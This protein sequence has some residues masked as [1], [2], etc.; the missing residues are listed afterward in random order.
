M[1]TGSF[2]SRR[3]LVQG[4]A[5]LTLGSTAPA[6]AAPR[7]LRGETDLRGSLDAAPYGVTPKPGELSG[8]RFAAMLKR[9]AADNTPVFLPPGTYPVE[10]LDL[11][12]NLRLSGVAGASRLLYT[13]AGSMLTARRLRRA[14]L[15]NL[16][17]DGGN[18][19]LGGEAPALLH[20]S[21]VGELIIDNCDIVGASK[22]A[23][24]LERCAARIAGNRISG[25]ADY[26]LYAVD[27]R[28]TTISGNRVSACGNGGILVHR[29]Q[30]GRDGT[31]VTGN[32]ITDIR[33]ANGG[34]GPFGNA[35]NVFRADN[36]M[37]GGN[38]IS[39]AAFSAIRA[40]AASDVQIFDNQCLESGETAIYS[41]FGFEGAMV[42]GNLI[43][44]AA[45]G[46]SVVNFDSGGRL[47]TIA[48]NMVRNIS[49][50][51]PYVHDN[52][53]FGF[54]ISA[55]ADAAITG[56]VVENIARF[57]MLV[58]W[59]PY[60]RNVLASGNIIRRAQTGMAVSVVEDAGQALIANNLFDETPKGAIVGYRWHDAATRDL[61]DGAS[62]F[63]HL[64]IS[65]NRS[66]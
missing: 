27:G 58:G 47:A 37:V 1:V 30:K 14:E 53:G 38:H 42:T 45:N 8:T 52:V 65:G 43:D 20:A 3:R 59:G 5:L 22:S 57:G 51:G 4:M 25:A 62:G 55:E 44:G 35:I 28:E 12:D 49:A 33:A 16:I 50:D 39:G 48:N 41:E 2:L 46:I 18:A 7:T 15:S 19:R 54:G 34:T 17:I 64:A 21:D 36:V 13:G 24:H 32:R 6:L 40:N 10:A 23:L 11:P 61:V 60:L 9:A 56:N 26:A 63:A 66:S 29:L 31:I